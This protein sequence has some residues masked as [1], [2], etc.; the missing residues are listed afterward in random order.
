MHISRIARSRL[1]RDNKIMTFHNSM[2]CSVQSNK[3]ASVMTLG[4]KFVISMMR[5]TAHGM[6]AP[7]VLWG[8][9]YIA[10][11][12]RNT[13]AFMGC[14]V[15]SALVYVLMCGVIATFPGHTAI[16]LFAWALIWK[17]IAATINIMMD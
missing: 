8:T 1:F 2:D 4:N 5:F 14:V 10:I 16:W 6:M 17:L 7:A 3:L 9:A 12:E 15:V 11:I 13:I